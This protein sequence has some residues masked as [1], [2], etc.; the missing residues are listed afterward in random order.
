MALPADGTKV[1]LGKGSL[2]LDSLTAV[3]QKT[4]FDFLGNAN[5]ITIAADVTKAQLFGSTTRTAPLIAEA[6]TRI[7]YTLTANL[8][9]FTLRNLKKF[10]L[11]TSAVKVQALG[12]NVVVAFD[13][14]EVVPDRYLDVAKRR[15]TGVVVTRDGTDIAVLGTDYTVDSEFG[16]IH[17]LAGGAILEGDALSVEFDCP[18]LIID[19][20]RVALDSAPVCHLLYIAD[21]AN[22]DGDS[23]RDRLE[24]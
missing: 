19:Q 8:N 9:E 22:Q 20:I 24:I 7:A 11:G 23:A 16:L 18:A 12:T 15:I 21:D 6:V 2:L 14:E 3:G 5:S 10:L 1:K 13:T 17:I 4:G